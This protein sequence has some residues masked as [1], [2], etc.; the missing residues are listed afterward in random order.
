MLGK[1]ELVNL[2]VKKDLQEKVTLVL[3]ESNKWGNKKIKV[4]L[5]HKKQVL[6]HLENF[7]EQIN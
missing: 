1:N 6:I 3:S 2:I 5:I 7:N 4:D